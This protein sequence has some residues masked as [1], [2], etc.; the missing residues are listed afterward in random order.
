MDEK[1]NREVIVRGCLAYGEPGKEPVTF[2]SEVK[3][4]IADH[5]VK[6][7][8]EGNTPINEI[9]IPEGFDK[10]ETEISREEMVKFWAGV[11]TYWLRL[12]EYLQHG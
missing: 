7:D 5:P 10:V 4:T 9:F 6:T 8:K 12:A 2:T 3:A 1:T 11:E